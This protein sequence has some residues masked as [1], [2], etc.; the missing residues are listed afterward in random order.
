[1]RNEP[2]RDEPRES[3]PTVRLSPPSGLVSALLL[4]LGL[5]AAYSPAWTSLASKWMQPEEAYGH[6]LLTLLLVI[7]LIWRILHRPALWQ[8]AP[9][10]PH[11]ATA[12]MAVLASVAFAG[13]TLMQVEI[14]QHLLLP[15]AVALTLALL[16][17]SAAPVAPLLAATALLYFA[18]PFWD[19]FNAPL[20]WLSTM[21]AGR[22]LELLG[23]EASI[24]GFIVRLDNGVF[25]VAGGCSG[26]RYLLVSL[27]LTTLFGIL[28]L[29]RPR[30]RLLLLAAGVL[31]ALLCNWGRVVYIIWTGHHSDM[32]DPLV[33]EHEL[34][35]WILYAASLLP[36]L[37]IAH[38]L[39]LVDKRT[40]GPRPPR[41]RDGSQPD[42]RRSRIMRI[43]L[44]TCALPLAAVLLIH[45][46]QP[47]DRY[48]PIELPPTLAEWERLP[49][50]D[51]RIV[52]PLYQGY[53]QGID[54]S[55]SDNSGHPLIS[56]NLR[57]YSR[58]VAGAELISRQNR[59]FDPE[60]WWVR[61]IV[62]QN[63]LPIQLLI[64]QE[65]DGPARHVLGYSYAVAG[66][67]YRDPFRA[68]LG[69]LSAL[70]IEQR[71]DGALI[72]ASTPCGED[73]YGAAKRLS[74]FL[75]AG[76]EPFARSL[77]EAY[78]TSR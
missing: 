8:D 43:L 77:R 34:F 70:L 46:M 72:M 59:E 23:I 56:L 61:E 71:L 63:G 58:Q 49:V 47:R 60:Q 24:S 4:V 73:C 5:A 9:G 40:R 17:R 64:V 27:T 19:F 26:L 69:Q 36:L 21:V 29:S 11:R 48:S 13:A 39:E 1:M 32:Q 50:K 16:G 57:L 15:P 3:A 2:V 44:L 68:K 20:Q 35:G 75:A 10:W 33:H 25:E 55:Y 28:S 37:G 45:F 42:V 51:N 14:L 22:I 38:V 67:F 65:K 62:D 54:T 52:L 31:F 6:G 66:A 74:A 53:T 12:I 76:L 7:A 18:M 30:L 41:P 78:R